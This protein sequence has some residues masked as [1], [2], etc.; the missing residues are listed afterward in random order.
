[1]EPEPRRRPT[2]KALAPL[3]RA[4]DIHKKLADKNPGISAYQCSLSN[5]YSN[6]G[7]AQEAIGQRDKALASYEKAIEIE[8]K[9]V[10]D[11]PA[12]I[13]YRHHLGRWYGN[14]AYLQ[15]ATGQLDEALAS[16][17]G[18]IEIQKELVAKYPAVRY[19]QLLCR[20]YL[21]RSNAYEKTGT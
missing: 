1:M 6:I 20:N 19:R 2:D 14:F 13:R 4:L 8:K 15:L 21:K 16:F 11:N 17:Q 18:A 12:V 9:V 7:K 5:S 10:D 3:Q